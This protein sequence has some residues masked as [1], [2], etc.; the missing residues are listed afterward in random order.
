MSLQVQSD[1]PRYLFLASKLIHLY[2]VLHAH[3]PEKQVAQAVNTPCPR[4]FSTDLRG[5]TPYQIIINTC[6]AT[7]NTQQACFMHQ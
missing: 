4:P 6:N 7:E 1:S 3:L 5:I 2:K